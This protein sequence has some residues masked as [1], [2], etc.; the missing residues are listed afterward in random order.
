MKTQH[1]AWLE[2]KKACQESIIWIEENNI[3]SLEEAWNA[4]EQGDW[5]LWMAKKLGVDKRKLALCGALCAH[6][7][8]QYM[9]NTRSRNA[10]RIAFLWGRG[11]ATDEQLMAAADAAGVDA[12]Y[13]DWAARAAFYAA[14]DAE[15]TAA[16]T[17]IICAAD[18]AKKANELRTA[19]IAKKILTEDVINAI[20][21]ID[22]VCH[23]IYTIS[24]ACGYEIQISNDGQAA[25]I[26]DNGKITDWLPIE[27]CHGEEDETVA[28]IDPEGYNINLNCVL[29][30]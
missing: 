12:F 30:I 19:N 2:N 26:R 6:T 16:W 5:L 4:C 7:V 25:R 20:R 15:K 29:T 23:G 27:F 14:T 1:L 22:F 17:A 9:Q 8:V 24:N 18:G 13:T 28:I 11:K 21:A 10:V 3:Q